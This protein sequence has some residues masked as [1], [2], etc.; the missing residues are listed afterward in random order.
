MSLYTVQNPAQGQTAD[1]RELLAKVLHGIQEPITP[2]LMFYGQNIPGVKIMPAGQGGSL[3]VIFNSVMTP[4]SAVRALE[5]VGQSAITARRE[6]LFA[7]NQE[8]LRQTLRYTDTDM[9]DI[10]SLL[11][12]VQQDRIAAEKKVFQ[13]LDRQIILA[14]CIAARQPSLT[15]TQDGQNLV[16]HLGGT[17]VRNATGQTTADGAILNRYPSNTTGFANA[18]SDLESLVRNM[19]DKGVDVEGSMVWVHQQFLNALRSGKDS[20]YFSIDFAGGTGNSIP[21]MKIGTIAGLRIGPALRTFNFMG[22]EGHLPGVDLSGAAVNAAYPGITSD[23]RAN[24][25]PVTGTGTPVA[26]VMGPNPTNS[27]A[28]AVHVAIHRDFRADA[29]EDPELF[30]TGA[31]YSMRATVFPANPSCVGTIEV[32]QA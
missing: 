28:E 9:E 1:P 4:A 22:T 8:F 17:V 27:T 13:A 30:F 10:P 31:Q 5:G 19:G 24:F 16:S 29:L 23:L 14:A 32:M 3:Q 2:N 18:V 7:R 12:R 15:L 20:N 11:L 26:I 25:A 6:Y 21:Y